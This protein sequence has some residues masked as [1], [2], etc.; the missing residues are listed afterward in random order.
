M[1]F[2]TLTFEL[3][4][5]DP[6]ATETTCFALGA[7]S[8]TLTD[9]GD[10]PV[11]E[12]APGE[13]RLWPATR[14]Q[15]LFADGIDPDVARAALAAAAGL[16]REGIVPG[17]LEDRVWEREW[18]EN[19]HAMRFGRRLWISPRHAR[20]TETGAVIIQ[21][22]PGL[23]FGSG[24]HATTALCLE[25]LDA[26]LARGESVIDYGCGSGVLAIAAARLGAA[27]AWCYD[28][29][30]QALIAARDNAA[31]NGVGERVH[32]VATAA[33]L[34][35]GCD[36]LV[37]N[38]LAGTLRELAPGLAR[39]VRPGGRAVLSG[40]LEAQAGEVTRA[41]DAWFDTV[42][43]DVRDGWVRLAARRKAHA[44]AA[45]RD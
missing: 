30:A 23:A 35:A 16:D 14:V 42:Q 3:G 4:S 18:L 26:H 1:P 34:P 9:V 37:A 28:I 31:A 5:R 2:T 10:D 22:D 43:S 8:V 6:E 41:Y 39:L 24:T 38:I 19:F 21:L 45:H 12:P 27:A 44:R 7:L 40:I 25:W 33:S 15:A 17:R 29:D 20:V 11:L 36:L 32:V 13:V